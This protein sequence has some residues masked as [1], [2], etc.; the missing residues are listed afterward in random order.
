MVDSVLRAEVEGVDPSA[1]VSEAGALMRRARC[2]FITDP[3][4]LPT[5]ASHV[6]RP[7][8]VILL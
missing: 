4:E 6:T 8:R 7:G 1:A 3:T 5:H 2:P